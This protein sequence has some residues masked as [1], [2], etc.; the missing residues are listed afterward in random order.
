ME[1][2]MDAITSTF[3]GFMPEMLVPALKDETGGV[4]I[5]LFL[6]FCQLIAVGQFLPAKLL[7]TKMIKGMLV[8]TTTAKVKKL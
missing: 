6:G 3:S 5:L 1:D 7:V 2:I 4:I 8:E